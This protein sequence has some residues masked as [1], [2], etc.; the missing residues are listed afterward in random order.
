VRA[1]Q[2][3]F[4]RVGISWSYEK[5]AALASIILAAISTSPSL[6]TGLVLRRV[7]GVAPGFSDVIFSWRMTIIFPVAFAAVVAARIVLDL[8]KP[9]IYDPIYRAHLAIERRNAFLEGSFNGS[10]L[11]QGPCRCRACAICKE[12]A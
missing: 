7:F 6:M 11:P 12:A 2:A 3:A 5:R 10:G 4:Q 8:L 1:L 9:W